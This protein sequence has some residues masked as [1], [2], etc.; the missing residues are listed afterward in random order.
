MSDNQPGASASASIPV[1]FSHYL[2]YFAR[3]ILFEL[4]CD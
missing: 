3:Y 2:D 4:R 1:E